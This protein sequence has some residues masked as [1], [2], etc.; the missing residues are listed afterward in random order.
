[1]PTTEELK[2]IVR[3][4]Y[5]EIAH[6]DP[7][8]NA[9][10]CCGAGPVSNKVYHIM[11]DDYT[12]TGGYAP[13]ADLG[14]GCGLPVEHA[15]LK[16]G[17]TVLDLGAGAGNDCFVAR[18]EVGPTG[19]VIGVDFTPAMLKKARANADALGYNNV[20]FR[21]GDID[22]LPV[23][24]GS[25]DVVI[26]NC[27]LNLVPDKPRVFAEMFRVL[28]PGAHFSVSDVVLVGELPDELRSAAELYAGCV[29]GAIQRDDYLTQLAAAGFEA[30]TVQRSKPILL[31]DDV[32]ERYLSADQI[33]AFAARETG[34]F[35]ITVFG[36][37]PSDA[38]GAAP[39]E[40][41]CSGSSCC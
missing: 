36:Q 15:L 20:E 40:P 2:A 18:H 38:P 32:L 27:V 5:A 11:M 35:S 31:P 23:G 1:M 30:V 29:A 4:K 39:V 22:D 24:D 28:K 26:S 3:D 10:S 16:R 6:Q 14:L 34:I 33:A 8:D 17:Q 13:E 25:V 21:A 41:C 12:G 19:K 7:A 9:A 37:K